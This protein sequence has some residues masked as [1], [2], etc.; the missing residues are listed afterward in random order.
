MNLQI[1]DFKSTSANEF[2]DFWSSRYSYPLEHIYDDNIGKTLTEQRVIDLFE[3]KNGRKI[4][5]NKVAS[6]QRNYL[7]KL[8]QQKPGSIE[9]G[10]VYLAS[11][12][13]G[14]VWGI[15]WLHCL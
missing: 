3:W 15:F 6:I 10:R 4:S 7:P 12:G 8:V 13:G 1:I 9:E 14:A 5:G 2:I 11:L